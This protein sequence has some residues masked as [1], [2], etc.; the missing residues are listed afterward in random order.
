M[1]VYIRSGHLKD[2][3]KYQRKPGIY[4]VHNFSG[5]SLGGNCNTIIHMTIHDMNKLDYQV[6]CGAR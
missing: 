3:D 6:F 1:A 2:V 5:V 4:E